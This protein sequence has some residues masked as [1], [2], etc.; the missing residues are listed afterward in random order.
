MAPTIE[1]KIAFQYN[2][3]KRTVNLITRK[4][5]NIKMFYVSCNDGEDIITINYRFKN[6]IFYKVGDKITTQNSV[7]IPK[8]KPAQN[9]KL[10]VYGLLRKK[11]YKLELKKDDIYIKSY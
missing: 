5:K 10:T 4:R 8:N 1:N 6:A 11:T 9:V 2:I 7:E 3:L